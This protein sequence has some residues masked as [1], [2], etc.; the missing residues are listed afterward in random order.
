MVGGAWELRSR[1][2]EKDTG[3][4][5]SSRSDW[6]QEAKVVSRGEGVMESIKWESPKS[7]KTQGIAMV[8]RASISFI[9]SQSGASLV[10]QWLGIHLPVQ[11]TWL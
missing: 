5:V 6:T 10:A 4:G 1:H 7:T 2:S 3:P 8:I 9:I 11:G